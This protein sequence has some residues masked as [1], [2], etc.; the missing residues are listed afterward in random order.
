ME[1][2]REHYLKLV[3]KNEAIETIREYLKTINDYERV[4]IFREIEEGYCHECGDFSPCFCRY[5]E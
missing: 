4:D 3:K 1:K 2:S 5:D